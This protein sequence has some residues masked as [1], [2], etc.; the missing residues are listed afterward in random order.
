MHN[1]IAFPHLLC[2]RSPV[3]MND[4]FRGCLLGLAVGEMLGAAADGAAGPP[5]PWRLGAGA[6]Q[7]LCLA[8]SYLAAGG[9]D[10][11]DV[12]DRLLE[13]YNAAPCSVDHLTRAACVNLQRGYHF[14]RA[15]RDAWEHAPTQ[16]RLGSGSLVRALPTGLVRYHDDIHLVG[17][18]RVASGITHS[19]EHCK[20]ACVCLNLA[21][22]HLLMVGA[23]GLLDELLDFIEP[24]NLELTSALKAIPGLNVPDLRASGQVVDTLQAALWAAIYCTDFAEGLRILTGQGGMA[25][26]LG[27]VG[28]ALLG[29]RFGAEAVPAEWLAQLAGRERVDTTARRLFTLCQELE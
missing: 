2:Y 26:V 12:A 25:Q 7:M 24:R 10:P 21:A 23:D 20:L 27:A 28:G 16:D 1:V 22:A 11:Q 4:Q 15:G 8:E 6:E 17:E 5:Q 13:W 18:S 14:E 9:F 29:V 19:D 3:Q